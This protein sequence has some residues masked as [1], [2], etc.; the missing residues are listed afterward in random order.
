MTPDLL[1]SPPS[2]PPEES[3]MAA[4]PTRVPVADVVRIARALAEL[5]WPVPVDA[6]TP[7]LAALGW[8]PVRPG[9]FTYVTGLGVTPDVASASKARG[10]LATVSLNL[11]DRADDASAER[12]R[13]IQDT[14]GGYV[15]AL[16]EEFGPATP[17]PFPR[18]HAESSWDL[19]S[20]ARLTLTATPAM[21]TLAVDSPVMRAA[22]RAAGRPEQA[23]GD[24]H[25][26]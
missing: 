7:Q 6:I 24:A 11:V 2:D 17:A 10:E 3:P 22:R 1:P 8:R 15:L 13:F 9:M 23:G 16:S 25:A 21:I 20:G 4:S 18:Q 5:P 19:D 12:E 26:R 14:S